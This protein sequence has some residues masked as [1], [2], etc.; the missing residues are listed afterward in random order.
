VSNPVPVFAANTLID[1]EGYV[2]VEWSK[3]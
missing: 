3:R 1:E 2:V